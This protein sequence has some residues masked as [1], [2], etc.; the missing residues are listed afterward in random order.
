M[1]LTLSVDINAPP[2][3]VWAVWSDL[4]RWPEWTASITRIELLERPAR[5]GAAPLAVGL[6]AR[7]RQPK[8]PPAVWRVTAVERGRAFTWVSASPGAR[9]TASHR[10]EAHEGG[11]LAT[12]ALRVSGPLAPLVGWLSR[13]LIE[14][15]L[16]MEAAGVKA[17]SEER[18][19]SLA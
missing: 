10:V 2:D 15:Y 3:V 6:R 8:L 14:R 7:V 12:L 13:S 1:Q 18:A 17:R 16:R 11:S 19:A 9:V 5:N 4:E